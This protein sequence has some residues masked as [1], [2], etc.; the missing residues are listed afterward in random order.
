MGARDPLADQA[1]V[2]MEL[3]HNLVH[4]GAIYLFA[5][6]DEDVD[7]ATPKLWQIVTSTLYPH[8]PAITISTSGGGLFEIIEGCSF[9]T[10]GDEIT[11]YNLNRS[12]TFTSLASKLYS[13]PT[14]LAGGT[15]LEPL[16]LVGGTTAPARVGATVQRD[17]EWVLNAS[18]VYGLRFTPAANGTKISIQM[19]L[20]ERSRG[21]P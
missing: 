20:Y 13:D 15:V 4:R 9:T 5:D 17:F 1:S 18:T 11:P 19:L 3:S 12:R 10:D 21:T 6:Y 7:V 2:S 8:V 14:V 16:L